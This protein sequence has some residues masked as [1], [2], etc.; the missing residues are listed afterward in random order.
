MEKMRNVFPEKNIIFSKLYKFNFGWM[1]HHHHHYLHHHHHCQSPKSPTWRRSLLN[2]MSWM[3]LAMCLTCRGSSS[4]TTDMFKDPIWE[5]SS[6][7]S[8]SWNIET[9][10]SH[11]IFPE[12][13]ITIGK[14]I[15]NQKDKA[16]PFL[17]RYPNPS[18]TIRDAEEICF[19]L[20]LK[21][22]LYFLVLF[23]CWSSF[24]KN[25]IK[26]RKKVDSSALSGIVCLL[27]FL[28]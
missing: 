3:R 28:Q 14:K 5:I 15:Y 24:N 8:K 21:N 25:K 4:S 18:P 16:M 7:M 13:T 27:V 11:Q 1:H 17:T 23:V 10:I 22:T 20:R 26:R 19:V 9:Y 2:W 6:I 12:W